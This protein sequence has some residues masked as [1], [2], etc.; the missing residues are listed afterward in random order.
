MTVAERAPAIRQDA[1]VRPRHL[2]LPLHGL[3]RPA[4]ALV[5]GMVLW[6]VLG[7]VVG[8]PWLPPL[9]AVI[10]G[11]V[12]LTRNGEILANLVV[13]LRTLV[14]GFVLS[15]VVGIPMGALMGRSRRVEQAFGV[16]VYAAILV[17]GLAM[18]PIYF[19][20]FGL[21]DV[22]RIL[23]VVQFA[24]FFLIVNT[25]TAF[26][27]V[28]GSLEEMGRSFGASRWQVLQRIVLPG[29]LVL[30]F[31]GVR[32]AV[33]RAIKGMISGEMFIA[34]VGLGGV[35][36]KY[37]SQFDAA[38]VL[39]VALVTLVLSLVLGAATNAVD[40]RFTRWAD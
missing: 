27:T 18:A 19:A 4:V 35:I 5:G 10:G 26:R 12:E 16:Y 30:V 24:A 34:V 20:I 15:V 33:G 13:T 17:P 14:V 23:I 11:L 7:R 39:A 9:S 29:S 8:V 21:S 22:T 40:R 32:I 3:V 28:D 6:E 36:Q 1:L 25:A 2:P 38:K 37:G 31:A